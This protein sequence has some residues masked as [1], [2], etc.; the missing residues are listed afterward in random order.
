MKL[1]VEEMHILLQSNSLWYQHQ[2]RNAECDSVDIGVC[3]LTSMDFA[4]SC[5]AG[6]WDDPDT[7]ARV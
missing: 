5:L 3:L 4:N 1:F 7:V 2:G 6:L